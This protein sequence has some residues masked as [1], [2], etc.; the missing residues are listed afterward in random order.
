MSEWG[1]VIYAYAVTYVSLAAFAG[2]LVFRIRQARR[3]LE[4][5]S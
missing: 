2:Y 3:R 5:L 4:E 1:W